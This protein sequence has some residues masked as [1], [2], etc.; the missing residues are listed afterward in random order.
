MEIAL[1]VLPSASGRSLLL[2]APARQAKYWEQGASLLRALLT[3][4]R[5]G[6]VVHDADLTVTCTNITPWMFDGLTVPPAG[7]R[8]RSP[9]RT[10]RPPTPRCARYFAPVCR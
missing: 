8:L 3:R 6:I 7:R 4:D 10:P 9:G 1:R 5:V 2:F